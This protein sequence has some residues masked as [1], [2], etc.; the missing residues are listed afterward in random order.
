MKTVT[1]G[2]HLTLQTGFS[3]I[4]SDD[5]I[6][7]LYGSDMIARIEKA[8]GVFNTYDVDDGRF[9]GK[10]E[11][12]KQTGSL[13][14][15]DIRIKNAGEY[16][17]VNK[18]VTAGKFMVTVYARLPTPAIGFSDCPQ[19]PAGSS[20]KICAVQCSVQT[21]GLVTLSWYKGN[22]L[23]SSRISDTCSSTSLRLEVDYDDKNTYSCMVNNPISNQA[24][25]LDITQVCHT[26]EVRRDISCG[27]AEAVIRL[28]VSALMGVAAAAAVVVLIYDIRSRK[29]E[30]RRRE[31]LHS[32][33]F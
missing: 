3:E 15:K 4:R 2:D 1:E 21:V 24:T 7:W 22:N 28:V 20:S 17:L 18:G 27:T 31:H 32:L 11:L 25:H 13:I 9:S 29:V 33:P 23:V 10:L 26:C 5:R 30:H 8:G 19:T 14:I 12:D 16:Q 6:V